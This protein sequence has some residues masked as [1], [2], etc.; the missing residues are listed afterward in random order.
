MKKLDAAPAAAY[1]SARSIA[2]STTSGG[3]VSLNFSSVSQSE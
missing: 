2:S 3:R 1:A